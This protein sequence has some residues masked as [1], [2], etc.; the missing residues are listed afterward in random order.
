MI[1]AIDENPK[2]DDEYYDR[3]RSIK[4]LASMAAICCLSITG[5]VGYAIYNY[6]YND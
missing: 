6:G 5:V 4:I 2:V 1:I 3:C